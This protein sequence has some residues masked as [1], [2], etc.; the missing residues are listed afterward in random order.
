MK[1]YDSLCA[2]GVILLL[3]GSCGR[4]QEPAAPESRQ[5]ASESA[6][7]ENTGADTDADTDTANEILTIDEAKE[8]ILA[9]SGFS[10]EQVDFVKCS[11]DYENGRRVYEMEFYTE[12]YTEYDY[13]IDAYTGEII[14]F[15]YEAEY[16][17]APGSSGDSADSAAQSSVQSNVD[18]SVQSK[19]DN[20]AAQNSADSGITAERAKE[21]ALAQVPGAAASDIWEFETDYDDGC[22]EYEGT[23]IYNG[24]EYEFEIDAETGAFLKWEVEHAGHHH[25]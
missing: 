19:T 3:L 5:P 21:L 6:S 15:E 2:L 10:S 23:I 17:A 24:I 8:K 11:L 16:K 4:Q 22:K 14:S 18:S 1:R 7:T 12:D 25:H 13:A 9:H 20:S